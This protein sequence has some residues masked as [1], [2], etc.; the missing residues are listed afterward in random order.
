MLRKIVSG[1]VLALLLIGLLTFEFNVQPVK[2]GLVK[3]DVGVN[4][5]DWIEYKNFTFSWTSNVSFDEIK[6]NIKS[7]I[8][9]YEDLYSWKVIVLEISDTLVKYQW[10]WYFKNGSESVAQTYWDGKLINA[11]FVDV[12]TGSYSN[13]IFIAA[14]LSAGDSIYTNYPDWIITET[15][16]KVYLG[17][18]R[19]VNSLLNKIGSYTVESHTV[20]FTFTIIWDRLTGILLEWH[21]HLEIT[22]NNQTV[23]CNFDLQITGTN[24]WGYK[25][26]IVDD[27]GPA[28]FNTIQKAINVANP[29]DKIFI[30]NGIYYEHVIVNKS[31]SIVGESRNYTI[32]DGNKTGTAIEITANYVNIRRLTIRNGYFTPHVTSGIKIYQSNNVTLND[33]II[34][35]NDLGILIYHSNNVILN[36]SLIYNNWSGLGITFGNYNYVTN[37]SIFDNEHTG[38]AIGSNANGNIMFGNKICKNHFCGISIGWSEHNNIVKNMLSFNNEAGIR[39]DASDNNS[40]V[41]N[42][43]TSSN[44]D[45]IVLFGSNFNVIKE[46]TLV[47]NEWDGI[48]VWYSNFNIIYHNNFIGNVKQAGS[49]SGSI[50]LWDDD[51]PSGGNYW[52]DYTGVDLYSGPYQNETGSDGIGDTSYVID[53]YNVDHYPL[54]KPWSPA[55]PAITAKVNIE[56]KTLNLRSRGRWITGY[57][58]LP[59]GYNVADINVSSIMLNNTIPAQPK[60]KA[61][62]DYDNDS[63]PDL[64]VKFDKA[65]VISYILTNV[66]MTELIEERFMT[67]TLTITGYLNDG[68]PFQ[69]STKIKIIMPMPR[70]WKFIKTLEIYPI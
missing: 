63:I 9:N 47:Q 1:M 33:C 35:Q 61:V 48:A 41:G 51:Y 19:E 5:G 31:V 7:F 34:T 62:G 21:G 44:R 23:T 52:S 28:D 3:R 15:T 6:G 57:I 8:K 32:V 13:M 46:N 70:C 29:G 30:R 45:G 16:Q 24:K 50:N 17:N 4:V 59:E 66:N 65:E 39:L 58:E 10:L 25:I 53:A 69:G 68:T 18:S 56:P 14:N 11:S 38:I 40:I 54:M 26:W 60:P 67:I 2:T 36:N 55:P 37:N 27:D 64:M 12:E 22:E 49:Y 42:Y 20:K 43:I